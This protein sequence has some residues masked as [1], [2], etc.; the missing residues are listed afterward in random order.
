MEGHH[1][2]R[3]H[4]DAHKVTTKDRYGVTGTL[5]CLSKMDKLKYF[6]V[7][8]DALSGEEC[9]LRPDKD[10]RVTFFMRTVLPPHWNKMEVVVKNTLMRNENRE[11]LPVSWRT[12][13]YLQK[14]NVVETKTFN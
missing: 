8:L 14:R 13:Q 2:R 7:P 5:D 9:M 1:P 3:Y 11:V 12:V 10:D 6:R 4:I